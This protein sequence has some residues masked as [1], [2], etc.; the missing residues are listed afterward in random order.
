M[1]SLQCIKRVLCCCWK[2]FF[3]RVSSSE[4]L[5]DEW[6]NSLFENIHCTLDGTRVLPLCEFFLRRHCWRHSLSMSQQRGPETKKKLCIWCFSEE[7]AGKSCRQLA[8]F[9]ILLYC[10]ETF[11][12][13]QKKS[14]LLEVRQQGRHSIIT[15]IRRKCHKI[16]EWEIETRR[17]FYFL[18]LTFHLFAV[19]VWL[20]I[21]S[22]RDRILCCNFLKSRETM[23]VK[24][25]TRHKAFLCKTK[26]TL[27]C[28]RDAWKKILGKAIKSQSKPNEINRLRLHTTTTPWF[29]KQTKLQIIFLLPPNSMTACRQDTTHF[30][31][32]CHKQQRRKE[33]WKKLSMT[34]V[35][36]QISLPLADVDDDPH[37]FCA[38]LSS[39]SH[40][41]KLSEWL[42]ICI[43]ISLLTLDWDYSFAKLS[44]NII[45]L[46]FEKH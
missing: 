40:L 19:C 4:S 43:I 44:L 46:C 32:I 17:K 21:T 27:W 5:S 1:N 2:F 8:R 38:L 45:T 37:P 11:M 31:N 29:S 20:V 3:T 39:H 14:R 34:F 23:F 33:E 24:F 25:N 13:K 30:L 9:E 18:L 22:Q 15:Y 36:A 42:K 6:D 7:R 16:I 12:F 41:Q 28:D 35:A 26:I 10:V